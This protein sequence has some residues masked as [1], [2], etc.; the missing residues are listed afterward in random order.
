MRRKA[1][2]KDSTITV[3]GLI[4][5]QHEQQ[6]G[7]PI[8]LTKKAATEVNTKLSIADS[9]Y[10]INN[11]DN[12]NNNTNNNTGR[13]VIKVNISRCLEWSEIQCKFDHIIVNTPMSR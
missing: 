8:N 1:K 3:M 10:R 5:I 7:I 2:F 11:G 9:R 13:S 12:N 6:L 4:A